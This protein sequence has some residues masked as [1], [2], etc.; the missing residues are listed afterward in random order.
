MIAHG[1][2]D[3]FLDLDPERGL[4][5]GER[6][7][8]AL[9]CAAEHCEMVVF[10]VSPVLAASKWRLAESLLAQSLHKQ[11]FA[12]I[13]EPTP[14]S[15]LATEMT[16]RMADHRPYNRRTGLSCHC[17]AARRQDDGSKSRTW[18]APSSRPS[19]ISLVLVSSCM[20][21]NCD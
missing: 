17:D 14:F 21:P 2:D 1:W 20:A 11:I 6:W 12:V 3:V 13:V 10:L 9:K 5:A 15:E 19:P 8:Q 4:K 18:F 16:D 7:Q